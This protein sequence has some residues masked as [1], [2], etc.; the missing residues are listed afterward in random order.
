MKRLLIT[1]S[2]KGKLR[3]IRALLNGLAAELVTPDELGLSLDITEDGRS[4]AENAAKK[5]TAYANASGLISLGDDSG[6]EVQAL[7]GAP[8]LYSA[9][10][11]PKPGASDAD[12]RAHLLQN[13]L[14]KPRPWTARFLAAVA[15]AVPRQGVECTQGECRGEIIDEERG[16][17]GFGYDPIFLLDEAGRTMAELD[18]EEKNRLS[19]RARAIMS[20]RPIFEKLFGPMNRVAEPS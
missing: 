11:V 19:H 1:T 12:R 15:I 7:N 16:S 18:M 14:G 5:A 8:G 9:R 17:R 4:Y 3:E 13:L 20:A 2:N 10:Y 6:L